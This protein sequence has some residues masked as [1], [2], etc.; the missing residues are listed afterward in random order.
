[1]DKCDYLW[2]EI[3]F[4]HNIDLL[5]DRSE[6]WKLLGYW[7]KLMGKIHILDVNIESILTKE[8]S[9]QSYL[10]ASIYNTVKSPH[11]KVIVA[12]RKVPGQLKLPI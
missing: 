10:D 9:L 2:R 5:L 4:I 12:K 6:D 8:P 1:L 7:L 3:Q 11:K